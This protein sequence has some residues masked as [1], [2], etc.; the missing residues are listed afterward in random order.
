MGSGGAADSWKVAIHSSDQREEEIYSLGC[1]EFLLKLLVGKISSKILPA[2]FPP[3]G[4]SVHAFMA[5]D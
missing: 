5:A 4:L 3:T 1:V 2:Q